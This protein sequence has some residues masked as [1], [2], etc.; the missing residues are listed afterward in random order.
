MKESP[1]AG[2][3]GRVDGG[4]KVMAGVRRDVKMI[5]KVRQELEKC[6]SAREEQGNKGEP[7]ERLFKASRA[8]R[9]VEVAEVIL[10]IRAVSIAQM[11][12]SSE[13]RVTLLLSEEMSGSTRWKRA[14]A[15]PI[16]EPGI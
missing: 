12:R 6:Q 4:D 16:A 5:F 11:K 9:S 8:N 1:M 10:S 7:T 13:K 15:G 3:E 14:L 2:S